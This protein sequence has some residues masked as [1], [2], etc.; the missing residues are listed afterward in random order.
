MCHPFRS[1]TLW[2]WTWI[3]YVRWPFIPY[4]FT[5]HIVGI[6]TWSKH[7]QH[8]GS[9]PILHIENKIKHRW[10]LLK[11]K[12]KWSHAFLQNSTGTCQ[13]NKLHSILVENLSTLRPPWW[14]QLISHHFAA[15]INEINTI[16]NF[17]LNVIL[18]SWRQ[19]D[20][21]LH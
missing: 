20:R 9:Q 12:I 18:P 10:S 15:K 13:K 6:K 1:Y 17:F 16:I 11:E 19:Q 5:S 2:L 7:I 4:M 21:S 8:K 14:S 3:T